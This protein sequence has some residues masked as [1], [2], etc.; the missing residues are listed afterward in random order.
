[1]GKW[2]R[3]DVM[4]SSLAVPLVAAGAAPTEAA[5]AE[6]AQDAAAGNTAG[7]AGRER[8][9]MDFGWRFHFGHA[10]DPAKDFG[11]GGGRSGNFQKTGNFLPAS[12]ATF[13]DG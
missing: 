11:F 1:M 10:S 9:L 4:K 5:V 2:T 13:D 6:Q 8:L 7:G 12:S 3:R